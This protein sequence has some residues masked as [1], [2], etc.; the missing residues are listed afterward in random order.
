MIIRLKTCSSWRRTELSKLPPLTAFN[1]KLSQGWHL[2]VTLLHC[3][4]SRKW[5]HSEAQ[6]NLSCG[7]RN[8][9][10]VNFGQIL[11][12]IEGNQS[13]FQMLLETL[14]LVFKRVKRQWKWNKTQSSQ[15]N[16]VW[17][18]NHFFITV[19][20]FCFGWYLLALL[21]V[22]GLRQAKFPC[23]SIMWDQ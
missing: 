14:P 17:L 7:Q 18:T 11:R 2:V 19:A 9:P 13:T 8:S 3:N 16:H 1:W 6:H 23:S 10:E 15:S 21:H 12:N 4:V 22:C 20:N 5:R